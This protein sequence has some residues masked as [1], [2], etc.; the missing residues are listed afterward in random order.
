MTQFVLSILDR[1]I[2]NL[3]PTMQVSVLG[4]IKETTIRTGVD[5]TGLERTNCTDKGVQMS[6]PSERERTRRMKK[7]YYRRAGKIAC[8]DFNRNPV[9]NEALEYMKNHRPYKEGDNHE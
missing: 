5:F 4:H 3:E 2:R 9:N 1:V 7:D 8:V 6:Q